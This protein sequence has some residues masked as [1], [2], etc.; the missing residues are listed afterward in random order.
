MKEGHYEAYLVKIGGDY[1]G[2]FG[3]IA[4]AAYDII[5]TR[6]HRYNVGC[7]AP[8]RIS[9]IDNVADCDRIGCAD[10]F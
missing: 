3:Q 5:A 9:D 4:R 10:P 2:L 8:C 1:M 6:F 7:V